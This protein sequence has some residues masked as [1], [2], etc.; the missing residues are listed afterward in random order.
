M[1]FHTANKLYFSIGTRMP[2]QKGT[3]KGTTKGPDSRTKTPGTISR[4]R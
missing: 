3:T 4:G 1:G 2:E